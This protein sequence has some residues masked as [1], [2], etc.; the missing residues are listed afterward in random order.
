M[1]RSVMVPTLENKEREAFSRWGKSLNR[2]CLLIQLLRWDRGTQDVLNL[3]LMNFPV[4]GIQVL[5]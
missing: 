5:C 2:G 1:R 3:N 4:G